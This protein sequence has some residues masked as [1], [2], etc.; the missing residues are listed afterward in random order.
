MGALLGMRKSQVLP[1]LTHP[2]PHPCLICIDVCA[3]IALMLSPRFALGLLPHAIAPRGPFSTTCLGA[4]G[5]TGS[6]MV[7]SLALS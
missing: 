3:H 5:Q 2:C 1:A 4:R 7:R 6:S